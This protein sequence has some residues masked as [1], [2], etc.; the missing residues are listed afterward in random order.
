[1]AD[2]VIVV[3]GIGANDAG[4]DVL[5]TGYARTSDMTSADGSVTWYSSNPADTLVATV[6]A[7][8]KA[9]A[10]AAAADAGITVGALDKK[11]LVGAVVGL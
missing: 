3:T 11:T 10:M 4:S 8:I 9:A 6:N 1:M 2:I 7:N 5:Y